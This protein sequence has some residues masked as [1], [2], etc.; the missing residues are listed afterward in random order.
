MGA[1][2]QGPGGGGG[3]V[4]GQ[5]PVGKGQ[6]AE[7]SSQWAGGNGQRPAGR[8]MHN[9]QTEAN[10]QGPWG[11]SQKPA[12]GSKR[13]AGKARGAENTGRQGTAHEAGGRGQRAE[14]KRRK[15]GG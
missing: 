11:I 5:R 1:G 13:P 2:R 12:V 10:R 4:G 6:W 9:W 14:G 15:D 8:L 3:R 7:A